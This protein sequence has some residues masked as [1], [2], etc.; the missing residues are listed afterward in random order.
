MGKQKPEN[1]KIIKN[2]LKKNKSNKFYYPRWKL[3]KRDKKYLYK[4]NLQT[5]N[6]KNKFINSDGLYQNLCMAIKIALDLG[7]SKKNRVS[8]A[9]D[10]SNREA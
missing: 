5:I 2:I 8:S 10:K 3:I 9:K 6:L 7:I 1:N 4:D